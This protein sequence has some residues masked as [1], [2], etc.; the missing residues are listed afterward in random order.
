MT[1]RFWHIGINCTDLDRTIAFYEKFGFK[2]EDR[3]TV[4]NPAVG[5][6][7]MVPGGRKV[8]HAHM[9]INDNE[10][11]SLLDLIQW[12][13]PPSTGYAEPASQINPG[14]CRFSILCDDIDERY[15]TLGNQGVEFVQPPET[16]M[17]PDGTRGWKILF[18]KDPDGTLFHFVEQI[19]DPAN[20]P[21]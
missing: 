5:R 6:A 21:T 10:Y 19:G 18:A 14:L 11:E 4:E 13:D 12:I 3:G 8:E 7:F 15:E 20:H 17:N 9:R 2:L 1:Y 16:V